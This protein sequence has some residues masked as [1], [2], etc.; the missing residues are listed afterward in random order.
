MTSKRIVVH[1]YARKNGKK[2]R[3]VITGSLPYLKSFSLVSI[4][5]NTKVI[6][7][8]QSI[9]IAI[10]PVEKFPSKIL[11]LK[12]KFEIKVIKSKFTE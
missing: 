8:V 1:T 9:S 6:S 5:E 11:K 7:P 10:S 2:K 3:N 4:W 12:V